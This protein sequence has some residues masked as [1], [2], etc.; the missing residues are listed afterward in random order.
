[1][2]AEL[3][4]SKFE[5]FRC[6]ETDD[7]EKVLSFCERVSVSAGEHLWVEGSEEN[8]SAFLLEGKIGIKKQTGFPGRHVV[9]GVYTGGSVIG[10][11]CLLTDNPRT[12]SADVIE[13]VDM[14]VLHSKKFEDLIEAFP[15][16]GLSLLRH[17]FLCTSKRLTKSYDRIATVF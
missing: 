9:V 17:I 13:S 12:V 4:Q 6:F 10:E 1:M 11:L 2:L 5:C 8:Y 7:L 14:V 15:L 16:I 3:L